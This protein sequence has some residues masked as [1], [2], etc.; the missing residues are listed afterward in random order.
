MKELKIFGQEESIYYK[1][2]RPYIVEQLGEP[3]VK[4]NKRT[5]K[6]LLGK[7][8]LDD[9]SKLEIVLDGMYPE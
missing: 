1:K 6:D 7:L 9:K 2:I 4:K 3:I 5:S 8:K